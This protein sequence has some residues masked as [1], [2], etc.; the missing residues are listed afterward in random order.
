MAYVYV[1]VGK[2]FSSSVPYLYYYYIHYAY[3]FKP[4]PK[5]PRVRR[6]H[7]NIMCAYAVVSD[8]GA[9]V[10]EESDTEGQTLR[11]R[12]YYA[13]ECFERRE[14]EIDDEHDRR[15]TV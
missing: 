10:I 13:Y 5:P 9:F 11:S 2:F 12:V 7:Y 1:Y 3:Y 8:R 6:A 4:F 14:R 15:L